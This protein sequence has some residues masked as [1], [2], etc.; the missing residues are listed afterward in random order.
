MRTARHL[1]EEKA[2]NAQMHESCDNRQQT[3]RTRQASVARKMYAKKRKKRHT[4][5]SDDFFQLHNIGMFEFLENFDFANRRDGKSI[6]FL[7][8]IESLERNNFIRLLVLANKDATVGAFADLML[9]F[10]DIDI[11][12]HDGSL[13]GATQPL[14]VNI[15]RRRWLN[16]RSSSSRR[17]GWSN[18]SRGH[19]SRSLEW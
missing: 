3:K 14:I 11:A 5:G 6:L 19:W 4:L 15:R 18:R 13:K 9:A 8:G 10:K 7:L 2:S 12:Q 1:V 17:R 16:N